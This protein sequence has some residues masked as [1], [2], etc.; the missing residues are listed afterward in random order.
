L[1]KSLPDLGGASSVAEA[2]KAAQTEDAP[3]AAL[4]N[5]LKTAVPIDAQIKE[6]QQERKSLSDKGPRD[7]HYSQGAM[8][9]FIGT[10]FALEVCTS[11]PTTS[12]LTF[13]VFCIR[14]IPHLILFSFFQRDP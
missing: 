3:N 12:L 5:K 14:M 1:K 7:K 9:A 11:I 8:L 6:L 4:I 13:I 10:V 2:L